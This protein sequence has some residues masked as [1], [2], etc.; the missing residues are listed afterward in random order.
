MIVILNHAAGGPAANA[1]ESD[2]KLRGLFAERGIAARIVHPDEQRDLST[3][4][5]EAAE[6]P[7]A[8]VVAGGGDGTISAVAG[9]LAGTGKTLGVLPLGTLNH[10]A[11]DLGIPLDEAA[12]VETIANG[13]TEDVDAAEVNG[14]VFINNSSL[15]VYPRIV[16]NREAQ[17]EQLSRGKWSAALWAT[18]RA[19]R[20]FPFLHLRI[21]LEAKQLVR[22]T[23]FLFVG[24]NEYQMSGFNLGSRRC[25][26][27]GKL[28]LYLTHRTGRFGLFRL[29]FRALFGRLEQAEDFDAFCV[30]EATIETRHA[31][32]L[33]ATDGEVN[34]IETP[35]RYRVRPAALR[36]L[37][38][39][40]K[41]AG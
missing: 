21:T 40:P 23:A 38:P 24:N 35:L 31:R 14:R 16:A 9:A 36:V 20:R 8:V 29:G 41:D 33:V 19:L 10:F 13:Y 12:A 28:G 1:E 6:G 37:V 5:R 30:S 27:A 39:R 2:A 18:L 25:L 3:L 22:D 4:V 34:W 15:G 32:L 26:N 17:Q 11:K 7:D